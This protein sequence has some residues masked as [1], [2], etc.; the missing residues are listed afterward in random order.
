MSD[1]GM[2]DRADELALRSIKVTTDGAVAWVRLNRPE[3]ANALDEAAW[4]EI[5]RIMAW[6][7]T[8]KDIRVVVLAGNGRHFCSGIEIE[9][10]ER[11]MGYA[12]NGAGPLGRGRL[13]QEILKLQD[14]ISSVERLPIPVIAAVQ[15]ACIGGGLDLA[16]A[17][18]LRYASADAKF[19]IKEI[20]FGIVADVGSTQRLRHVV[21][22]AVLTELSYTAEI[23][24]ASRAKEIGLVSEVFQDGPALLKGVSDLALLIAQKP[25]IATRGVKQSL[26]FSRD[27]SVSDGLEQVASWNSAMAFDAETAAAV[28]AFKNRAQ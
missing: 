5:P 3:R 19:C 15:G 16:A 11:L 13:K 7:Q 10:L 9:V 20:D 1:A 28:S 26:I 27:H 23:V 21:G 2:E 6:I 24:P 22:M 4:D 18:D 14:A 17:C 8:Q 25:P 12:R